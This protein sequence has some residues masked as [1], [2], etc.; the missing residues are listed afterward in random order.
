MIIYNINNFANLKKCKEVVRKKSNVKIT[1][2]IG[3]FAVKIQDVDEDVLPIVKLAKKVGLTVVNL[4]YAE[5]KDYLTFS[6]F[7]EH[8][9]DGKHYDVDLISRNEKEE[10]KK[11]NILILKSYDDFYEIATRINKI[12]REKA[13]L[14]YELG[15][16]NTHRAL[17]ASYLEAQSQLNNSTTNRNKINK[18]VSKKNN[19]IRIVRRA[20]GIAID[21]QLVN[22]KPNDDVIIK[23]KDRRQPKKVV[24]TYL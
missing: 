10:L 13:A 17:K 7:I 24:Y 11:A 1:N 6:L 19:S 22:V 3:A 21:N 20:Y 16:N 18:T 9:N 4:K 23:L 2:K 12:G 14:K 5:D 8:S 15:A